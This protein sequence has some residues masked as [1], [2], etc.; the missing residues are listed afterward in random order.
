MTAV[1]HRVFE[2]TGTGAY[3]SP[4]IVIIDADVGLWWLQIEPVIGFSIKQT[5]M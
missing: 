2:H 1:E 4:C 5:Q 3:K